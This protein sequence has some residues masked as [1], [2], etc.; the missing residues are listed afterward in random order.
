M[1][2]REILVFFLYFIGK[3]NQI[4]YS[5]SDDATR[6]NNDI[7]ALKEYIPAPNGARIGVSY[8][9]V[10]E[11]ALPYAQQ[12]ESF[13]RVGMQPNNTS[14]APCSTTR[15]LFWCEDATERLLNGLPNG[16]QK[17]V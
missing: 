9:G 10:N 15:T 7:P 2:K 12:L 6:K 11:N 5:G 8:I 13:F 17:V 4:L 3:I 16:Y 14:L 1:F